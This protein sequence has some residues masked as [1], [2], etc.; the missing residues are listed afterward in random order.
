MP[1]ER[2]AETRTLTPGQRARFVLLRA[3]AAV[4]ALALLAPAALGATNILAVTVPGCPDLDAAAARYPGAE[5]VSF[6]SS[7]FPAPVQAVFVPAEGAARGAVLVV[8]GQ[9]PGLRP[10]GTDMV[11]VMR[12]GGYHVLLYTPRGCLSG[13]SSLGPLEARGA[14]DALAYLSARAGQARIATYGFSQGGAAALR[15]AALYPQVS[16]A[17]AEGNYAHLANLMRESAQPLGLLRGLWLFGA[18]AAYRLRT[19]LP[20]D[21][22]DTLQAMRAIAPRPVLLVYGSAEGSLPEGRMLAAAGDEHAELL[23]VPGAGHGNYLTV[24]PDGYSAALLGFLDRA[25]AAPA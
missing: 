9:S 12:G 4:L 19:G 17:V 14:G 11:A 5:R 6:P 13:A 2:V 3:G 23:L 7:E 18:D 22:L 10:D 15:A 25:L 8:T 21:A 1:G 20:L 24:D 16:A